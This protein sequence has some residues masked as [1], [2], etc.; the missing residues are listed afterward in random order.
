MQVLEAEKIIGIKTFFTPFE[1]TGG[2]LR[3]L[4]DDFI[5]NEISNYPPGIEDGKFAIADV[6]TRNY[7]TNVLIR[8]ISNRLHISRMRIGFAGTKDKRAVTSR[9]MSF[10]NISTDEL[11]KIK[12][13][14]VE[15]CNIYR[16]NKP[17]KIGNLI[18][19]RF[20]IIIRKIDKKFKSQDVKKVYS[21]FIKKGGFPNFYGIQRFGI[22]R[23]ITHIVGRYIVKDDF[24]KA[25]MSYIA[26]PIEGEDEDI[27]IL[28]EK[29][30][31]TE[32]FAVA[33]NSYPD[34]LNYEKAILN[35]LIVEKDDFIGAIKELP[36]NLLTMFI[37]GYQSYLF[38]QV[39]SERIKRKLPLNEAVEGDIILPI[40]RGV[41]DKKG[42]IV[43][44]RNID[45]INKQLSKSKAVISGVLIGSDTQ[46]AEGEMGEIENRIIEK[47]NINPKDFIIPDIPYISSF[48]SR[49]SLI[50]FIKDFDCRLMK[51][52]LNDG[53]KALFLRFELQKGCYATSLLR[54]FMKADDIKCY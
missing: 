30:Q 42:I 5:V 32:D 54:E 18:G 12:I 9:L 1:G 44:Q 16:S 27:F 28:R 33:L 3:T 13:K 47:E 51:D 26:N 35:R 17:V 2:K 29:L 53:K 45:K 31:K 34:S 22:I 46:I 48:G 24:Q 14:D 15:L 21:L 50:G 6:K 41:L 8:D 37:N 23:P 38:N 10:Y 25:V 4:P 52:T 7:E 49:R 19:N 40:R 36:K 43:N 11:S 20:E 39:L